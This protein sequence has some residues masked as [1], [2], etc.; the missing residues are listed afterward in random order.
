MSNARERHA[1][2]G[3][4]RERS[5]EQY[6]ARR[7]WASQKNLLLVCDAPESG[8]CAAVV[9]TLGAC[10]QARPMPRTPRGEIQR[11]PITFLSSNDPKLLSV[12]RLGS[13]SQSR[14]AGQS[15]ALTSILESFDF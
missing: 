7:T 1:E 5:C 11:A 13:D 2:D 12:R 10:K 15:V 8:N 4:K 3:K 14:A 9:G 6:D